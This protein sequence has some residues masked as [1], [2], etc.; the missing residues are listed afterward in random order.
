MLNL[1]KSTIA[2]LVLS[3]GI[4]ASA[5]AQQGPS[6]ADLPPPGP[7]ASSL[8]NIPHEPRPLAPS[9]QYI[10]PAPGAVDAGKSATF[11]KPAGYDNDI[12]MHPYNT[13]PKLN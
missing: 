5:Q 11:Q 4:A 10:G 9:P 1:V 6:I 8:M 12:M 13:G 2:A 7:R 3:M